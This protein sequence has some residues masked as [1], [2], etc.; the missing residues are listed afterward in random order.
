MFHALWRR[1]KRLRG[2]LQIEGGPENG[3]ELS[4]RQLPLTIGRGEE[5]DVLLADRWVSRRHCQ[6]FE[7][8]GGLALRDL[9]SRHGTLV[10][11]SLVME[12][13][14]KPGDRISVG[15]TTLVARY[16]LPA[17]SCG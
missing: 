3:K 15:M 2:V 13:V 1:M 5:A 10:N 14:I 9:G 16:Q 6:I 11:G 4:V 17:A 12:T 8:D 7:V